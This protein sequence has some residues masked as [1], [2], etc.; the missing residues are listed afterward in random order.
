[1]RYK[2][3]LV[4]G[5]ATAALASCEPIKVSNDP[6]TY[7]DG[8]IKVNVNTDKA[9]YKPGEVVN[10]TL[11][12]PIEGQSN[13]MVRIKHLNDSLADIPVSG[14]TWTWQTPTDDFT[15]YLADLHKVIN[16]KDSVF[17]SIAIDVSSDPAVFVR[18]GFLSEYGSK[19]QSEIEKNIENLNRYHINYVQFQEWQ[20]KH[21]HPLTLDASGNPSETWLDIASRTNYRSTVVSY[22]EEAH[23]RGMK[24]LSY[25]LCYG[26]L[27]DADKDGVDERWYMF[28]KNA[29]GQLVKDVHSLKSPFKSSIY[30]TNPG[31]P[32]WQKYLADKNDIMYKFYDFD[33]YQIDQLGDRG[34]W[35][36]YWGKKMGINAK[37]DPKND[38]IY[39]Y[40]AF[41]S[42]IK[43]MK[44]RQPDKSLVM[45]AVSQYAQQQSI[46]QVAENVDFLYSEVWPMDNGSTY[47]D[48]V[49]KIIK[50]NDD[51]IVSVIPSKV[52]KFKNTVLAAYLNYDISGGAG[53]F[54][55]PGVLMTTAVAQAFGGQIL[56]MGEHM[57]CN[58]YFPNGNLQM[59][60]D[61]KQAIIH[62]YDFLVAYENVLREANNPQNRIVF[63]NV[64]VNTDAEGVK[65]NTWPPVL[66]E[67]SVVGKD[68]A[69]KGKK[70]TY[71]HLLNY[72][73][74][75]HLEWRDAQGT[76]NAPDLITNL[77]VTIPVE[78]AVT[79]V[80]M[81]SPDVEA[82]VARTLAFEQSDAS[83]IK[84]V[85]PSLKYWDMIA[86][87]Y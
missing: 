74:A 30:I 78:G 67:I 11:K 41:R 72:K 7:G 84:V 80:W 54:N 12:K 36:T 59:E 34:D 1:M 32:D 31:N 21:H 64:T 22:I 38:S 23:K 29:D 75:S 79:N 76:Q 39:K 33:G 27:S 53:F 61:L 49:E 55:T 82:G 87:E 48:L 58:E 15:G 40:N 19:S 42:F 46:C 86:I 14:L 2:N 71:L 44:Q 68:I 24:T 26:A 66:G 13:F 25:N 60:A 5:L 47:E 6:I 8:Y 57:L 63:K 18:N 81:A 52:S 83:N 73:G 16:G 20:D 9:Y 37:D 62:Y 50:A 70:T 51:N 35:Y 17:T 65:F 56:Q 69:D 85:I 10:F 43:Y 28:V 45:N 4:L 77:T 3:L